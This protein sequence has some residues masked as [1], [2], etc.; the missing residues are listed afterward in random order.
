M[1]PPVSFRSFRGN[2]TST[3]PLESKVSVGKAGLRQRASEVFSRPF[4]RGHQ[5]IPTPPPSRGEQDP[6]DR[7]YPPAPYVRPGGPDSYSLQTREE[8]RKTPIDAPTFRFRHKNDVV[9]QRITECAILAKFSPAHY[10][11]WIT[12]FNSY[13]DVC[14]TI[15]N[16]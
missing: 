13:A 14:T 15:S 8:F 11:S 9:S 1:P 4:S 7:Q 3:V 6:F 16:L 10:E 2:Q 12:Y 5:E